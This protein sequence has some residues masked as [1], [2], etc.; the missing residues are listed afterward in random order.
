MLGDVHLATTT[1]IGGDDRIMLTAWRH[2][3]EKGAIGLDL[4]VHLA[5][6]LQYL[7]GSDFATVSGRGFIAEPVRR[8][9]EPPTAERNAATDFY[10]EAIARGP[11]SVVATGEDSVLA[12]Y[13]MAAGQDAWLA[14]IP[15]GPGQHYL[16]RRIHGRAGSMEIPPDRTGGDLTVHLDGRDLT[17][18]DL[19][20]ELPGFA[21]DEATARLFPGPTYADWSFARID[22]AHLAVTF[23]DFGRAD[24]RRPAGRGGRPCRHDCRGGH[25]GRLRGGRPGPG[26]HPR[27]DARRRPAATQVDIDIALG[28]RDRAGTPIAPFGGAAP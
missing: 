6:V 2:L 18:G 9:G 17:S 16:E 21:F 7:L 27:R 28:L 24:P 22:A 8:R 23:W 11:E 4:A 13:R 3:R 5:D 1:L 25:P 15:S 12:L 19:L 26:R 10:S 20:R 14:F